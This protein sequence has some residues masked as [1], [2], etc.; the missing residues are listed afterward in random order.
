MVILLGWPSS[1]YLWRMSRLPVRPLRPDE[2]TFITV[3]FAAAV[4]LSIAVFRHGMRT[5]VKALEEMG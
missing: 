2:I 3:C 5:G 1:I 4:V